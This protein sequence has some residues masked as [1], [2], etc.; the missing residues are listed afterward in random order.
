MTRYLVGID[1][2]V[3]GKRAAHWSA[4][5]ANQTGGIVSLFSVVD[6]V[7][8]AG[9]G[10][11]SE[12]FSRAAQDSLDDVVEYI[13]TKYPDVCVNTKIVI[14]SVVEC[15]V[16]E[17]IDHDIIVVGSHHGFAGGRA[18]GNAT[19][20]KVS[21]MASVPTAVIPSDWRPEN[22]GEGIAVGIGPDKSAT[23]AI[24]YGIQR[25]LAT[26]QRLKL[27]SGWGLPAFLQRPAE[28][29]GGG[30]APVGEQFQNTLDRLV[31]DIS[32][33]NPGLEV[34]GVC[35]E[36]SST[37]RAILGAT[38]HNNMLVLGTHSY[39]ALGRAMFGSTTY[40]ILNNLLIPTVIVP[41]K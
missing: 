16:D 28:M 5:Q 40:S 3:Q 32:A 39:G 23:Q 9:L 13:K 37:A 18:F 12:T 30:I 24:Q 7:T 20:L 15:L 33:E 14:G 1:G 21:V 19:G 38:R 29:M 36:S 31:A 41:M 17:S 6:P 11:D 8:A 25:A 4:Y 26:K 34:K 2:S 27:V 22:A 10:F 35:E